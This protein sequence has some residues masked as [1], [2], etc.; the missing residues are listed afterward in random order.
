MKILFTYE[1]D[2]RIQQKLDVIQNLM[3]TIEHKAEQPKTVLGLEYIGIK[4]IM[5]EVF[6]GYEEFVKPQKTKY[7]KIHLEKSFVR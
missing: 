4:L 6:D 2:D 3:N 7:K 1:I 5:Q